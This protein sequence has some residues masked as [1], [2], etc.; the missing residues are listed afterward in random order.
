MSTILVTGATGF[1]GHHLVRSLIAQSHHVRCLTRRLN[2]LSNLDGLDVEIV[3]GDLDEPTGLANAVRGCDTV[4]HLAGRT[5][6]LHR[7]QLYRTNALGSAALAKACAASMSPPTLVVVSSLAAAGTGV[8]GRPRHFTD[9]ARPVS[10][11]GRSK[12]AGEIAI[13]AWA[14][15]VPISIVRPG[16]VFGPSNREM[17]PMFISIAKYH[18][19]GVPGFT[20]RRVAMIHHDDLTDILI[21]VARHGSRIEGRHASSRFRSQS[22]QR[23]YY[24][25][26]DPH[27]PTYAELGRMI[28]I[29]TKTNHTLLFPIPEPI[30]WVAAAG[31]QY[32]NSLWGQVDSFNVDKM[33][34][35]FAGHW[36]SDVD[37]LETELG[38]VRPHSLQERLNQT[39]QWYRE[40]HWL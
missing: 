7:Q 35:A 25:A 27:F 1:I 8:A 19:H 6:A 32:V 33:R 5:S 23:G 14:C 24:F 2:T 40:Q 36:I 12:R 16:I 3:M 31:Y 18:L 9:G 21:R 39:A 17:L 30:A 29:A 4:F 28:S 26:A 34:E 37:R 11:Y 13:A 10:D 38:F 20:P 22:P 15:R